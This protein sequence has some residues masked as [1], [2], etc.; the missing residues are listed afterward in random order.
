[1]DFGKFSV[2][3]NKMDEL[4]VLQLLSVERI[5]PVDLIEVLWAAAGSFLFSGVV[6]RHAALTILT[7]SIFEKPYVAHSTH[8]T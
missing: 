6:S 2:T 4:V 8:W 5:C 1:M 7:R 3:G